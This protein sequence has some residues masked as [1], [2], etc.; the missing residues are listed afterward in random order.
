MTMQSYRLRIYRDRK[1]GYRWRLQ[2]RNGRII[3]DSAES[4]TRRADARRAAWNLP[5]I[6]THVAVL[7]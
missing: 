1:G 3:A 2:T 4:Y 5:L 6:F 7:G